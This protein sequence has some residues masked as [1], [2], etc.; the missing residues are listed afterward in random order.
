MYAGVRQLKILFN[1]LDGEGDVVWQD[2]VV[3]ELSAG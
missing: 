3:Q 1:M 2:L